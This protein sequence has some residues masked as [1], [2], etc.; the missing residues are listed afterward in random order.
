MADDPDVNTSSDEDT[1]D[2]KFA[3]STSLTP[4]YFV[5]TSKIR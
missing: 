3:Y 2:C 5:K 1:N 4:I